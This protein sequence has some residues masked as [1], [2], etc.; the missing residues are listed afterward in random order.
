VNKTG[1]SAA[2]TPDEICDGQGHNHTELMG[3]VNTACFTLPTTNTFGTAKRQTLFGPHQRNADF[4]VF[5]TFNV[6]EQ[7]KLQFRAEVFNIF[8]TPNFGNPGATLNCYGAITGNSC[9][10]V[11]DSTNKANSFNAAN[12]TA[13]PPG[14]ITSLANGTEYNSRQIQFALKLLF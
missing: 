9:A 8:N 2:G 7:L 6:S 12:L 14:T 13:L 3:W 10:N 5:K 11:A 4:S 1:T